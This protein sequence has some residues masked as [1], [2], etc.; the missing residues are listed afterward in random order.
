MW[1]ENTSVHH[2]ARTAKVKDTKASSQTQNGGN[3]CSSA[4]TCSPFTVPD[5]AVG[6]LLAATAAQVYLGYTAP[7]VPAQV[8]PARLAAAEKVWVGT[9]LARTKASIHCCPL[10]N[11]PVWGSQWSGGSKGTH[12]KEKIHLFL[13]AWDHSSYTTLD[14]QHKP[15]GW[16]GHYC[17]RKVQKTKGAR[18]QW[19]PLGKWLTYL[20]SP[21]EYTREFPYSGR[22]EETS[23]VH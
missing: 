15:R 8:A 6:H 10:R 13:L 23:A 18:L 12:R 7:D 16:P 22:W 3:Q 5:T 21:A 11:W 19:S 4:C 2:Q 14:K 17:N 9:A 1:G 20:S